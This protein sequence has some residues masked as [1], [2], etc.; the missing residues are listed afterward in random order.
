MQLIS[1]AKIYR[2][3]EDTQIIQ[4]L[5][6]N[7]LVHKVYPVEQFSGKISYFVYNLNEVEIKIDYV[8]RLREK[9]Y[10]F[11]KTIFTNLD[12]Q[13]PDKKPHASSRIYSQ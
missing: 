2:G 7:Q 1:F 8:L 12:L 5:P 9:T 3:D 10:K 6:Q 13:N 11:R 4:P